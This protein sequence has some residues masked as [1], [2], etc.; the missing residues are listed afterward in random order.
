MSTPKARLRFRVN[1]MPP[2][3]A[4]L[5]DVEG[6]GPG[7][8]VKPHVPRSC[9]AF[10]YK[11]VP[12]EIWNK[13]RQAICRDLR[14]QCFFNPCNAELSSGS[15]GIDAEGEQ[16]C[17]VR[18]FSPKNA[19]VMQPAF[20]A[21]SSCGSEDE[22]SEDEYFSLSQASDPSA[23]KTPAP[24]GTY[25]VQ[26]KNLAGNDVLSPIELPAKKTVR[27]FLDMLP[28]PKNCR[29]V[30]VVAYSM[31]FDEDECLQ[32]LAGDE[33]EPS[34]FDGEHRTLQFTVLWEKRL[35]KGDQ[36]CVLQDFH[37]STNYR[38]VVLAK[39]AVGTVLKIL[40]DD[41][42]IKSSGDYGPERS[43][44]D[45]LINFSENNHWVAQSDLR[46][47]GRISSLADFPNG[48]TCGGQ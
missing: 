37:S 15:S 5:R 20:R 26:A 2:V 42:S 34:A 8:E 6:E 4:A 19:G 44:G 16:H 3:S 22:D 47:L 41:G 36:V 46:K 17:S 18:Q 1:P 11:L 10:K 27:E 35:E 25:F 13:D 31:V 32:H 23:G 45:A 14:A 30:L 9:R 38:P 29:I 7:S 21:P 48:E 33:D 24:T 43:F 28:C 39:G 40:S 12:R